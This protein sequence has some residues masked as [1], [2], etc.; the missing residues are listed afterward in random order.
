MRRN[1]A[2][3]PGP[4]WLPPLEVGHRGLRACSLREIIYR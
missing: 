1:D 3:E 2:L 4:A